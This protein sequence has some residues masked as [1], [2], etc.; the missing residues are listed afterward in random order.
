MEHEALQLWYNQSAITLTKGRTVDGCSAPRAVRDTD[1][2]FKMQQ[3]TY[4]FDM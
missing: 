4:S 2:Q 1:R 3:F